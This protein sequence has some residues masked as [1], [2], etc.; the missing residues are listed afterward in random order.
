MLNRFFPARAAPEP[1]PETAAPATP[2]GVRVYA[3]GDVHGCVGLLRRLLALIEA[4]AA[5]RPRTRNV[6]VF[7]GDYIDRGEESRGVI[8]LLLSAPLT[9][10][11]RVHLR[12]NHEESLLQFLADTSV[13]PAWLTYGG[14]ATLLS[15]GVKPPDSLTTP[16]ELLRARRQL[17]ERL[18][19][20]HLAFMAATKLAHVE[21]DYYFTH[22]G[23]RPGIP[24]DRQDAFD[25]MWI[26]DDFLRST[27]NFG[28]I[29]VHGHTITDLPD[30][31]RNRIGI[32]TGAFASGRLTCLVL[33]GA[34][35][36]FLQT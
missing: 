9:G 14:A 22:A 21:G 33:D 8:D 26:R 31:Q 19:Q 10:F 25:L 27:Q 20:E 17:A 28:K 32:D 12:G 3:V 30:V 13:G 7:L 24:L 23:V 35:A 11:D 15:Y 6:V 5:A 29:V 1:A 16:D 18:P 2:A 4:D 34:G 36:S